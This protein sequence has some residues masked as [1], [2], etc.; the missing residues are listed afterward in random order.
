V[1][2]R[3]ISYSLWKRDLGGDPGVVGRS[4]QLDGRA[5]VVCGIAPKGFVGTSPWTPDDL[6]LPAEVY[7]TRLPRM[8]TLRSIASFSLLARLRPGVSV[9]AAE[10]EVKVV[11]RRLC[12]TYPSEMRTRD[13][14]LSPLVQPKT[15]QYYLAVVGN[16][17]LPGAVLAL[18]CANVSALLLARAQG[19]TQEIATRLA[20]GG[21]RSR[22]VRQML[23]ESLLLALAGGAVGLLLATWAVRSL[24]SLLPPAVHMPLPE[25]YVDGRMAIFT[26][27]LAVV[28]TVCFGLL[29]AWHATKPGLAPLLKGDWATGRARGRFVGLHR[30]VIG[31]LT[32]SL[33]LLCVAGLFLRSFLRG[34]R[35]HP[36]FQRPDL[37]LVELNPREYGLELPQIP[38]YLRRVREA[39][40]SLPGVRRVAAVGAQRATWFKASPSSMSKDGVISISLPGSA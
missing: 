30:I 18:A 29:P 19:R 13:A 11:T 15:A 14:A 1:L 2:F 33:V 7:H 21:T 24:P 25:L 5:V 40:Q 35:A 10:A 12:E 32:V 3:S 37:L 6:W 27:L 31:Q 39:L 22:L 34:L 26:G 20:L 4:I 28:T 36:G 9:D 8:L 17:L 38:A 23:V 16:L